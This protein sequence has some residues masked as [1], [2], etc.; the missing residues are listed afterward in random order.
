MTPK[1]IEEY[2]KKEKKQYEKYLVDPK[3]LLLGASD[4]GKSTL[5][6]QLKIIHGGGFSEKEKNLAKRRIIY[7]ILNSIN[8]LLSMIDDYDSRNIPQV[9]PLF[10][11]LLKKYQ[12]LYDVAE[13][14]YHEKISEVPTEMVALVK[15]AWK[16]PAVISIFDTKDHM[17][18]D[19]T[20]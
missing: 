13:N 20:S 15:Q 16:E 14:W 2:L 10:F 3:I 12:A 11:N 17:L 8:K 6:K 1:E 4:S 9:I 5:L 7:G 18:P 19:T